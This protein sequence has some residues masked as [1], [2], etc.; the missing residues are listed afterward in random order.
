VRMYQLSSQAAAAQRVRAGTIAVALIDGT[1]LLV[2]NSRGSAPVRE[3]RSAVGAQAV[4]DRL[5]ASGLSQAQALSALSPPT[6]QVDVLE[7][8]TRKTVD[9]Q[10]LVLFG[11]LALFA[12]VLFTGQ[13]VAQGVTE[14]KSSR[15]VELLL[16]TVSPRRLLA[17]KVLGIG[18]V[19]LCFVLLPGVAALAAGSL[20]G[21]AGLPSAATKTIA[22]VMLWFVLGY[23]LFSVAYAA[24]G[25][26]VSRQED[27]GTAQAPILIVALAGIVLANIAAAG[28]PDGTLAQVAAF[29]PPFSPMVVP[30]RMV[31]G[32]MSWIAL[33]AAVALDVL[34][35]AGV[36]LLAARI[37][38]RSI[39]Q[40]GARVKL[41]H[42][43]TTRSH[44]EDADAAYRRAD[45]R[46]SAEGAYN[47]GVVLE[48]RGDMQGAEAAYRRADERGGLEGAYNLGDLL[49]QRGD[50][51]GAEAAYRRADER[52]DGGGASNLGILL[53]ERGELEGAAAAYRRAD[54]RGSA[55]GAYNLGDLL[56]QRGDVEG[57]E[58]A[59]RRADER[60]DGGGAFNLG[61]LLKERGEL[62]GAEAAYR[63]AV[64][65][66]DPDVAGRAVEALQA[67]IG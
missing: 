60:G 43:L 53:E 10:N 52:G 5:R 17:G 25:A 3:V 14:E 28:D 20:A 37:Y 49:E 54:E 50:L 45:E 33:S 36:I 2:K 46:G 62:E 57:A 51:Q 19:G 58:A 29:L 30:V 55:E 6:V 9:N 40:T 15:V 35:M 65:S 38:E 13:A 44:V 59:Y 56:E 67:L 42:V 18:T 7:L 32:H 27:L 11:V 48:E 61:V 22:L 24:V 34:A 4:V 63:R 16:T 31:V 8:N 64:R 47:L 21:G 23:C 41:T 66:D 39:L 12:V 26:M 1:R